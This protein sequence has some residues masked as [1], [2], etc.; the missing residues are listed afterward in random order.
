MS[1]ANAKLI[2]HC[3]AR[4]VTRDQLDRV[5]CPAAEGRRK[6]VPHGTVLTYVTQALMDA[7]YQI[8]KLHLGL[9]S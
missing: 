4:E 9:S 6:P 2:L 8:E 3:G 5:P 1:Q 7:G